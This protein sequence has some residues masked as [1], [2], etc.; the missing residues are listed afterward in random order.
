METFELERTGAPTLQFRG[1]RLIDV[2]DCDQL[3][4][5]EGR[6]TGISLYR[7]D[8]GQYIVAIRFRS[9]WPGESPDDFVEAVDSETEVEEIL[10]IYCPSER[11]ET[12]P[13]PGSDSSARRTAAAKLLRRY[14]EQVSAILNALP[15]GDP[16][17]A[18]ETATS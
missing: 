4:P 14:D 15:Q 17:S 13:A 1:E 12:K 16:A 7:A 6:A 2:D 18:S 3:A 10:S 5:T 8:D 11:I 9:T